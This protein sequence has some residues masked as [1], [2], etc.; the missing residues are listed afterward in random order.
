[1]ISFSIIVPVYNR[2]DEI[3]EL[4]KSL[5]CQTDLNFEIV[6]IEDGSVNKCEDILVDYKKKLNIKYFFK[7]NEGPSIARNYGLN[8]AEGNYFIFFDSDCIIPSHWMETVRKSL[9]NEYV[10]A[11]GGPDSAAYEFNNT[12]KAISYTMTSFL[13][14]G[15]TRGGKKQIGKFYPRSFNMGISR[16]L[17]EKF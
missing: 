15:G 16:N 11:F 4:L 5:G 9:E 7:Q 12:Q 3:K 6:I 2:P 10:D 14:T 13:T 17:F 1:M 8:K